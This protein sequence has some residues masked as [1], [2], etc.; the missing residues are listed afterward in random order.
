MEYITL[1]YLIPNQT[2]CIICKKNFKNKS[3]IC[4]WCKEI[5]IYNLKN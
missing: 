2:Y 4:M 1:L 3:K 5:N